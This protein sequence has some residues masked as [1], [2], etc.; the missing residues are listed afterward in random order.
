RLGHA[1]HARV[2]AARIGRA[3]SQ[4]DRARV[5][6]ADRRAAILRSPLHAVPLPD[7]AREAGTR[8][9]HAG[10]DGGRIHARVEDEVT[11]PGVEAGQLRPRHVAAAVRAAPEAEARRGV[12]VAVRGHAEPVDDCRV[13]RGR[14]G[15]G[16][17]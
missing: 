3:D 4:L 17:R 14:T 8:D 16:P 15:L 2:E 6:E 13:E 10:I 12:D 7:A 1:L 11:G 5:A 9:L